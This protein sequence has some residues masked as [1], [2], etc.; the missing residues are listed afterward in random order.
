MENFEL[1]I[2]KLLAQLLATE[3]SETVQ[4]LQFEALVQLRAYLKHYKR[5][6]YREDLLSAIADKKGA[7]ILET[8]SKTEMEKVLKPH[9][10]RYNGNAFFADKYNVPEEELICWSETSLRSPLNEAGFNRYMEVC[11]LV[12]PDA[13]A[14]IIELK[15]A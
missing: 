8:T 11:K 12:Y 3:S 2:I 5:L 13:F 10:P 4:K 9:A 14:D 6:G 1:I 15:G 7:M